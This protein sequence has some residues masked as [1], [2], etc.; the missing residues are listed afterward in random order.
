VPSATTQLK[1][2]ADLLEKGLLTREEFDA[3]KREI[4]GETTGAARAVSDPALRR[5]VGAYR[6]LSVIGEALGPIPWERAWPQ[7]QQ[8]LDAV[9]YAHQRGVVHRDLKPDN[10]LIT[11]DGTPHVIDFGIAKDLDGC[12]CSEINRLQFAAFRGTTSKVVKL[13]FYVN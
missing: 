9:G 5:S 1:D 11:G 6:V 2:L 10:V 4:L 7:M 8:L 13:P 3:Q 12:V